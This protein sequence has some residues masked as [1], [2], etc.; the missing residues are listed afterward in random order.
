[1]AIQAIQTNYAGIWFRSRLEARWAVF[2]DESGLKWKYE[3]Q[4]YRVPTSIGLISYLPDFWL[5]IGM[6]AEVKGHLDPDA[7]KRQ[8][9]LALAMTQCGNNQDIVML[10]DVGRDGSGMWPVQLH[11]HGSQLWGVP[12]GLTEGCP[13]G[14]AKMPIRS[15]DAEAARALTAGMPWG[16]PTWAE[17]GLAAARQARFE[18]GESGRPR[19]T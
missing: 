10:G 7:M 16:V 5:G 8:H 14:R 13:L 2:F 4:G 6:W 17:D 18:W 11:A 12:W 1:M 19:N 9:A 3:P 15:N